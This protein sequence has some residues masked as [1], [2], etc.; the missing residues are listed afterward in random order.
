MN[1]ILFTLGDNHE[2]AL[3]II[4][5]LTIG[6]ILI[7]LLFFSWIY[8][9]YFGV[10]FIK[11][12]RLNKVKPKNKFA[13]LVPARY[14][15][16]VIRN[17]LDSLTKQDYPKKLFDIYVIVENKHD[18]TVQIV[19]SYGCGFYVVIRKHIKNRKTKGFALDD[20]YQYIQ[21]TNKKYDGYV[22]FDADNVVSSNYLSAMNSIKCNGYQIGVGYRNFTNLKNNWISLSS[23]L[24]FTFINSYT[25]RARSILFSKASLTGTGYFIDSKIV[26]DAGGWIWN[27]MT[28]DVELT[29]YAY[30]NNIKM[31]YYPY[32]EYY[33]EQAT[34]YSTLHKQHV[35]WIWGYFVD[36]NK[37]FETYNYEYNPKNKSLKSK[38]S[39]YEQKYGIYPF[40]VIVIV[41]LLAG[42]TDF[43]IFVLSFIEGLKIYIVMNA[44]FF[45]LLHFGIA[46][47]LFVLL[48][49]FIIAT[50]NKRLK[51]NFKESFVA[52]FTYPILFFDFLLAFLD[53][54]IHKNKR[55]NRKVI[56]HSGEITN[57]DVLTS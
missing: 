22:V 54:L 5:Y 41:E 36:F 1:T 50:N 12:K 20:A 48:A 15:S 46:Y 52:A 42:L 4:N 6:I 44:F 35:R 26:D 3:D 19:E 34:D 55:K 47:L 45:T 28:E 29:Y 10:T 7:I 16:K 38:V 56:E 25:S 53:G 31:K 32:A 24:L 57:K 40:L 23:G 14:E 18:P 51:L 30:K 37:K 33:D 27:G 2:L 13:V 43:I 21:S 9:L 49:L 17:L 8:F 39:N 11:D